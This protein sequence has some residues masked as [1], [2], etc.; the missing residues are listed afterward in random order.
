MKNTKKIFLTAG[1]ALIFGTA[2]SAQDFD[3]FGDF[4]DF[5]GSDSGFSSSSKLEAGGTISTDVR[6]YIGDLFWIENPEASDVDVDVLPKANVFL[7]YN[8]AKSDAELNLRVD[9]DII[10]NHPFDVIDELV[11]RGYF[12]DNKLTAEVGKMKV[13]WG[14]G[15]K[16][17]VIDNFNADDYTDFIIPDYIDRRL[18]I[19]MIR[20]VYNLGVSNLQIEGVYAPFLITD[21]FASSGRWL[22]AQVSSLTDAVTTTAGEALVKAQLQNAVAAAAYASATNDAAKAAAAAVASAN[23][24]NMLSNSS[25]LS[26]DSSVL[27]PDLKN[28]SYGQY[29]LRLTGT[30]GIVDFGASYYYGWYKQPSFNIE[31]MESGVISY[32]TNGSL[33][34]EEKFLSYD[35]KQTFGLEASTIIWHFNVRGEAA[36]NLTNDIDGTDPYVH[37]NSL[38]WL[39]GFD[40]DLPFWNA[41]LNVQEYGTYI[42]KNDEIENKRNDYLDKAEPMAS[43]DVDYNPN[44]Y[45]NNKLAVNFTTSFLNDKLAPELTVVWGIEGGDFAAMP[46]IAYK[47]ADGLTLTASG[48]ILVTRD[49]DSEFAAW[50]KNSFVSVGAKYQF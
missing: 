27:Y 11:M 1:F 39:G 10:K 50:K 23:Y 16:L 32:L 38:S 48:L 46:K 9:E 22:P 28:L 24:V 14:K 17:H 44:G 47:P 6:G 33:S 34:E 26:S 41:N 18:S 25:K 43:S 12:F 36:Y 31:K 2:L 42:L 45:S 15:D 37:N 30:A 4:G 21:R 5:G 29:G 35:R 8:G 13:V 20:A 19:P 7:K 40:I 49:D 3:D